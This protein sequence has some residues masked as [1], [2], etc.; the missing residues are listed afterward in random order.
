MWGAEGRREPEP[1][2]LAQAGHFPED[3]TQESQSWDMV[4]TSLKTL[5]RGAEG[6]RSQERP[7]GGCLESHRR[8][9]QSRKQLGPPA[10]AL[11]SAGSLQGDLV[12]D[13]K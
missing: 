11:C 1:E 12:T 13:R 6:L 9:G 4:M 5:L 7:Q 10:E 8:P 3:A 2:G